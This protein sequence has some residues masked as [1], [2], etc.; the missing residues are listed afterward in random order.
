MQKQYVDNVTKANK[1]AFD[2]A[3]EVVDLNSS[4]L[5]TMLS[6][7]LELANQLAEINARQAKILAEFKDAPTAFQAQ[8]ALVQEIAE[9]AAGNTRDA[10]ELL[11]KSRAAYDKLFQ[12]GLKSAADSIKEAQAGFNATA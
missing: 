10:F 12:K 6:K 11:N 1:K 4:T 5:E 8:S 7:Q 2:A 9:Q 3:R